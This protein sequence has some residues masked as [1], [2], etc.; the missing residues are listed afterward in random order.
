M[1]TLDETFAKWLKRRRGGRS[2]AEFAA[3]LGMSE[4]SLHRLIHGNQSVTLKRLE[5]IMRR[6][7][8]S[9][10]EILGPEVTRKRSR[11]G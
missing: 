1:P 2:Y 3:E 4:S 6:L 7:G 9:P 5:E 8:V 11:R 10:V